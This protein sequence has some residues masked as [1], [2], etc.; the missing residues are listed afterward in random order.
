MVEFQHQQQHTNIKLYGPQ[1]SKKVNMSLQSTMQMTLNSQRYMYSIYL[2]FLNQTMTGTRATT[3]TAKM[4]ATTVAT[5]C[6]DNNDSS[7]SI[8]F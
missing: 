4:V 6:S 7:E 3:R 5:D 2:C 8:L 1:N